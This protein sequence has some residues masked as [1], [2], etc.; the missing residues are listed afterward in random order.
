MTIC[1]SNSKVNL[2]MQFVFTYDLDVKGFGYD[3]WKI[4]FG[5]YLGCYTAKHCQMLTEGG[6]GWGLWIH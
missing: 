6:L 3:F 1:V 5:A 2:M 4:T